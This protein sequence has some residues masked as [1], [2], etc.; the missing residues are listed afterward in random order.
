MGK[1]RREVL[2]GRFLLTLSVC[3]CAYVIYRHVLVRAHAK[4]CPNASCELETG[5]RPNGIIRPCASTEGLKVP[6]RMSPM[7]LR[8][9]W[10]RAGRY[11]FSS[12]AKEGNGEVTG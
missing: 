4:V 9:L 7:D 11:L 10:G 6:I 5:T 1:R 12:C 3:A 2:A 8:G